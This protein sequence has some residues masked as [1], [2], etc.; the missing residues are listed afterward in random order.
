[1]NDRATTTPRVCA[2][3]AKHAAFLGHV[4]DYCPECGQPFDQE[5]PERPTPAQAGGTVYCARFRPQD[6]TAGYMAFTGRYSS[7]TARQLAIIGYSAYFIVA[8]EWEE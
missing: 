5:Q 7:A 4:A 8:R 3:H 2:D 6:N 1:M